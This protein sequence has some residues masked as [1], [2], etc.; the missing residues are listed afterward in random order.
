MNLYNYWDPSH[1]RAVQTRSVSADA[2]QSQQATLNPLEVNS[3]TS[4]PISSTR[5]EQPAARLKCRSSPLKSSSEMKEWQCDM[6][7]G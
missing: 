1:Y 7:L 4:P 6:L 2:N 3:S 5:V